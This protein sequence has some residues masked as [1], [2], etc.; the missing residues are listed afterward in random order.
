MY[1]Y[2]APVVIVAIGMPHLIGADM[3]KL[4][5]AVID[6][7]FNQVVDDEGKFVVPCCWHRC[8]H[9]YRRLSYPVPGGVGP[10]TVSLLVRNA[11]FAHQHRKAAV[12]L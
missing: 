4:R 2:L 7:G 5:A 10:V 12:S 6:I 3:I 11:I 8:Y 1:S 9:T